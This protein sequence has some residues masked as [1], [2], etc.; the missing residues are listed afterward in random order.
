MNG[1]P[2]IPAAVRAIA[3]GLLL[4]AGS[5]VASGQVLPPL[6]EPLR[7]P[8]DPALERV[9]DPLSRIERR[10]KVIEEKADETVVHDA[11]GETK[12]AANETVDDAAAGAVESAAGT[13]QGAVMS[14][15]AAPGNAAQAV[16]GIVGQAVRPFRLSADPSGWPVEQ[17]IVVSLVHKGRLDALR[18]YGLDVVAQQELPALGL[19]M[20]TLRNP[21]GSGLGQ[22]VANL[23]NALPDAVVDFNHLYRFAEAADAVPE[24]ESDAAPT[25][26]GEPP[27][28]PSLRVGMI[29]SAVLEEHIALRESSVV[30]RDFVTN[31]GPRPLT[32]GTAVASLIARSANNGAEILSASVF[33]QAENYAPG[34]T[35]ESLVAA[36]DWLATERVDVINMSLAGPGNALLK[37]AVDAVLEDGLPIVAAVGNNGPSG[38][39]LHPAAYADV[40]AVTAVDRDGRIFLYANRGDHVDYAALGVNVKVADSDGTWRLESGTSMASPHVSVVVARTMSAGRMTL[41]ALT[42]ALTASAEDLGRNGFDSTFGHGL[43]ADAPVLLSR[44]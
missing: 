24:V 6:Q 37:A 13:V 9:G 27:A 41:G 20:V 33:F 14:A 12:E 10:R 34:A 8:L 19:V 36:L 32:H 11:V 4:L 22:T 28:A 31:E 29:D 1:T 21:P 5:G 30:A 25:A 38:D 7:R 16:T 15:K 40:I 18:G 17:D 43:I 2:G 3:A 26:S 44:Q 35:T 39:P 23:R 42:A